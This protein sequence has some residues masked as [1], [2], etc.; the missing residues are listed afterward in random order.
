MEMLKLVLRRVGVKHDGGG[1]RLK[2][3]CS[4]VSVVGRMCYKRPQRMKPVP[5]YED[6]K[7]YPHVCIEHPGSRHRCVTKGG[8]HVTD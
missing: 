4:C 8:P 3:T 1:D 5:T 6:L 2:D 7:S